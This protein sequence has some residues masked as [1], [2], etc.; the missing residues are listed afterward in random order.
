MVI[1]A[2]FAGL[3]NNGT[4]AVG[5][6]VVESQLTL[7]SASQQNPDIYQYGP[8]IGLL[9]GRITG[10]ATGTYTC[11]Q[12]YL[13]SDWECSGIA[14]TAGSSNNINPKIY[15]DTIVY[16]SDR[17]GNW[18]IYIYNLTSRLKPNHHRCSKQQSPV[19]DGNTIVWQDISKVIG[20]F[21][22]TT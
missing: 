12:K 6:Q 5:M 2:L 10:T 11:Y 20:E 14:I 7:N 4:S 3:E 15:N 8:I 9:S 21:T 1:L 22:A 13:D 19:I 18:D 17:N 16:Q